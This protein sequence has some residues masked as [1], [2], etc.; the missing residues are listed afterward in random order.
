MLAPRSKSAL[1]GSGTDV[2]G[3]LDGVLRG[4]A[5]RAT[6]LGQHQP[7]PLADLEPVDARR[8]RRRP[9]RTPSWPGVTSSYAVIIP[10]RNFQS[11][12]LTPA[13]TIRTRTS[14]GPGSGRSRSTTC[15]TDD[16]P[17]SE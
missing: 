17:V 4:G 16:G 13:R 15:S 6:V 8:R 14:P 11:V 7:D 1:S 9:P 5:V 10:A 2:V 12:G 3:R